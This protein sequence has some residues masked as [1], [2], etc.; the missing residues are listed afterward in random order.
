MLGF[1]KSRIRTFGEP[2]IVQKDQIPGKES[3]GKPQL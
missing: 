3:T 2:E 1:V